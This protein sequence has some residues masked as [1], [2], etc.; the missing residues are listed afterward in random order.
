MSAPLSLRL[1]EWLASLEWQ[2]VP[3][4]QRELAALRVLDTVGL[5]L[6]ACAGPGAAIVRERAM[7]SGQGGRSSVVGSA[8]AVS[9]GWAALANGVIAHSLDYD[10]TFPDSVVHPGSVIVPVALALGE[11]IGASGR[12][13]LTAIVGAY[14]VTARLAQIGGTGFH[15]RGFHASGV[16]APLAA[17]FAAGRLLRLPAPS[18]ASAAGLAASMSG[19]LLAFTADGAWSKW[20]HLGW[21]GFGGILAAQLAASG[22]RGPLGALDGRHNLFASFLAG[23][24]PT[25]DGADAGL[26]TRWIGDSALFKYYP[27]AHVIQPYIDLALDLRQKID[28]AAVRVVRCVVAPWAVPIVCEPAAEKLQPKSVV[29][30]IASLRFCVAS[31][32]VDGRVGIDLLEEASWRRA[33]LLALAERVDYVV[34]PALAGFAA[35]LEIELQDGRRYEQAGGASAPDAERLGAK[36]RALALRAL[37]EDQIA[38]LERAIANLAQS[39][40]AAEIA[41]ALRQAAAGHT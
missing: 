9:A 16:F 7:L 22:F 35:R 41:H 13:I 17:A 18:I 24:S 32:L 38:R 5:L 28:P 12:E 10:D 19:G 33:D 20:L 14:E 26:G 36:F 4:R 25:T 29:E 6:G 11:E 40:G 27:C 23:A 8:A 2:N 3:T 39:S 37:P 1:A 21:G 30:A 31:A 15:A 34:D